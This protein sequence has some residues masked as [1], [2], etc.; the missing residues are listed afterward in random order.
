MNA[1]I[2]VENTHTRNSTKARVHYRA[3]G[4]YVYESMGY[5]ENGRPCRSVRTMTLQSEDTVIELPADSY[6][7][8]PMYTSKK[9]AIARFK[10]PF[11]A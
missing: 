1:D 11:L 8:A 2:V 4:K 7:M 3:R 9:K 5:D 6:A 10:L